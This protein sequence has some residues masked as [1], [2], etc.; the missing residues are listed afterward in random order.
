M[1]RYTAKGL[2]YTWKQH[3]FK[4]RHRAEVAPALALHVNKTDVLNPPVR[5]YW[6]MRATGFE[7]ASADLPGAK[8]PLQA[9]AMAEEAAL[10]WAKGLVAALEGP[11]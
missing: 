5:W 3:G 11:R 4:H 2:R 9:K 10:V 1:K 8:T 6:Y 7:I